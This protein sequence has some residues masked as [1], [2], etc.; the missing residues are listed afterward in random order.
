M[1]IYDMMTWLDVITLDVTRYDVMMWLTGK[2]K[3]TYISFDAM[4]KQTKHTQHM[5]NITLVNIYAP[6]SWNEYFHLCSSKLANIT[7]LVLLA[8]YTIQNEWLYMYAYCRVHKTL[9][10]NNE[11]LNSDISYNKNMLWYFSFKSI[12]TF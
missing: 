7:K 4:N 10:A 9:H 5:T 12:Y 11:T 2:T 1:T 3:K 8:N 6:C